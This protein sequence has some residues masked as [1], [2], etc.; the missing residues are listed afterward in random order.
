M[1]G[2][3]VGL[4]SMAATLVV[5]VGGAIQWIQRT[6]SADKAG[7]GASGLLQAFGRALPQATEGEAKPFIEPVVTTWVWWQNSGLEFGIGSSIDGLAILLIALV[8]FIS[9]LVQIFSV[10]YVRGDRRYTHF[11]AAITLFS[12]G[13]FDHADVGEH[14]PA[15]PRL[16]DHGRSPRSC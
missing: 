7:E 3:E 1:K 11:F 12:G 10:D 13:M 5:A 6:D 8:A 16:G 4:A 9:L 14:G 15:D 2:A